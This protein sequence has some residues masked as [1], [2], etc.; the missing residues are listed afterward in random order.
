[1]CV[2]L[3]A[4]NQSFLCI[5]NC[6]LVLSFDNNWVFMTESNLFFKSSNRQDILAFRIARCYETV[7]SLTGTF[8][9]DIF[10]LSDSFT[11]Q[12]GYSVIYMILGANCHLM[13]C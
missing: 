6:T 13:A 3:R 10:V 7:T 4:Y 8:C 2:R 1:M 11:F 5:S 12:A 9:M